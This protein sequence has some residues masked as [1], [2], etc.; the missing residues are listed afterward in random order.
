MWVGIIMS[1]IQ[2]I[3]GMVNSNKQ[4]QATRDASAAQANS[5]ETFDTAFNGTY[6]Y[7]GKPGPDTYTPASSP[8]VVSAS[9]VLPSNTAGKVLA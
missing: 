5:R 1:V 2:M 6:G 9:T 7:P 3:M 4:A 8:Y